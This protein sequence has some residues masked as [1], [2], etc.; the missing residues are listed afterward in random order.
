MYD[1]ISQKSTVYCERTE[2]SE[3]R[4]T[5]YSKNYE[6]E[7]ESLFENQNVYARSCV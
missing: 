4:F 7:K 3:G 5:S 6:S 1:N 2:K